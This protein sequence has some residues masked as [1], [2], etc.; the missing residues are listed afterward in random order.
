MS[1]MLFNMTIDWVM[2]RT[3]E[4]QSRSIRWT[5]FSTLEDLDFADDLALVSHTHQHM[6]EK[7][8]RLSTYAQQVGLR[9]SQK[10]TGVMLLNVS[11][12]TPV[13]VNGED[14]PT[15]EEFT[16]LGSTVRH[17][18]GAGNNIKNRLNKARH[19][20]R[21]LNNVWRSSHYST[22]TKLR[23]SED[24]PKPTIWL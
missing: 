8:T 1:A 22:K 23:R 2:R 3:T 9:I 14:L 12:P 21:I 13:Q 10:K 7:T 11:N 16:Y 24:L 5:L 18:G 4:D 6:Q 20:F 15:T 17:D 19:A